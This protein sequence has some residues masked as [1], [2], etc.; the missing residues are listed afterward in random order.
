MQIVVEY[1]GD[2]EA[3]D[4]VLSAVV[5]AVEDTDMTAGA[6]FADVA[7]EEEIG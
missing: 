3:V 2:V 4:E 5:T 7:D 1:E 6:V